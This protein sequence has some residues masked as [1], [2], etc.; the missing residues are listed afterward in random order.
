MFLFK[1]KVHTSAKF[2]EDHLLIKFLAEQ[3]G[4]II[5]YFLFL[6]SLIEKFS[7]KSH[8]ING[9]SIVL[10]PKTQTIN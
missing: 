1:R 2:F 6:S 5:K 9:F 10:I 4:L 7:F 3:P 8:D